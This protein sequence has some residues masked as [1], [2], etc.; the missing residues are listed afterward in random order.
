[1]HGPESGQR[2]GL[3]RNEEAQVQ[4]EEESEQILGHSRRRRA[5]AVVGGGV[6]EGTM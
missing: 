6:R 3:G 5:G 2:W 1:M 4:D